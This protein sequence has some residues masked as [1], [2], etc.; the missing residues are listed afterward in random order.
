VVT[1]E[2]FPQPGDNVL[3]PFGIEE[4]LGVVVDVY[5][6]GLGPQAVVNLADTGDP[7]STVTVPADSLRPAV[8]IA[9]DVSARLSAQS[10]ERL[11]ISSV[12]QIGTKLNIEVLV[13]PR[14]DEGVDAILRRP[15]KKVRVA[16]QVK[17][18]GAGK[19]SSDVAAVLVGYAGSVGPMILV[20]N[21][22][23]TAAAAEHLRHSRRRK[24]PAWYVRWLGP[25]DDDELISAI[26]MAI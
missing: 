16:V 26:R 12:Q 14:W 23:L 2:I 8:D 10:Y 22:E 1:N 11:V 18:F 4:L 19:V 9:A 24:L 7:P 15:N 3:V 25:R 20:T 17:F 6:T 13:S 5:S 21:G